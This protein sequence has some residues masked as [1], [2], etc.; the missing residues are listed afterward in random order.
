MGEP[1]RVLKFPLEDA[2]RK[3]ETPITAAEEDFQSIPLK[4]QVQPNQGVT[5]QDLLGPP[6]QA[7][8][9]SYQAPGLPGQFLPG[10]GTALLFATM[11]Q[12]ER[13]QKEVQDLRARLDALQPSKPSAIVLRDV[14][15]EQ[16]RD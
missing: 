6:Y 1:A 9:L 7:L 14:S 15:P 2:W 13:L 12:V 10:G 8:G 5:W 16:A 11:P 4:I 3:A